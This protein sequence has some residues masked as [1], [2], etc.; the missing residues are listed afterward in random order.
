MD[1][2]RLLFVVP[3]LGRGGGGRVPALL[4]QYLNRQKFEPLLAVFEE[5]FDF[6][7]PE[8]VPIFCFYKKG[9]YDLLR[10]TW[11]LARLYEKEKPDIIINFDAHLP[12]IIA[13]KLASTKPKLIL[14][15][16]CPI[17]I[18][19]RYDFLSHFKRSWAIPCLYP[20]ADTI[21][22]CSRG[23]ADDL[24]TQFKIP[25]HKIRVIYTPVDIEHVSNLS[26]EEV[27]HPYFA[28]KEVPII[29]AVGRLAVEKG[30]P[31][32]I[33]AFAQVVSKFSCRLVILGDGKEQDSLV[34]LVRQLGIE[35]HVD[36]LGF[37]KNPFKYMAHSDIFVL[38]SLWEG[39]ALV[40]V[41]AMACGI[42]VISTRCNSGTSEVITD[43][44][45]GI[46]A[47]VADEN[48]LA[49]AILQ[50]L[51]DKELSAK[52][53]QAGRKRAEDFTVEKITKEYE[54]LF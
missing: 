41:E 25:C 38:S 7:V 23:I 53:A 48:A 36:F 33:T 29:I 52:L 21:I 4:L 39:L 11:Q 32:L 54:A 16:Q 42:P 22:C 20:E 27:G 49:D 10:L 8:D 5:R 43:G 40:I 31:Y 34:A 19:V 50:L 30:Y 12:P 15:V 37:Q 51:K 2:K 26:V 45:N 6:Y 17:S 9:N 44:V 47:P 46:L 35:R 24:V 18:R 13:K 28:S 1:R 14:S 3:C